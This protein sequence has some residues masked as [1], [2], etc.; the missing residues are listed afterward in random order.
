[1]ANYSSVV[2]ES[3]GTSIISSYKFTQYTTNRSSLPLLPIGAG[4]FDEQVVFQ[5][6]LFQPPQRN[7]CEES[8]GNFLK[9]YKQYTNKMKEATQKQMFYAKIFIVRKILIKAISVFDIMS[10]FWRSDFENNYFVAIHADN[11]LKKHYEHDKYVK[12]TIAVVRKFMSMSETFLLQNMNFAFQL[13]IEYFEYFIQKY[14]KESYDYGFK[15]SRNHWLSIEMANMV[16]TLCNDIK[17]KNE[18]R[19]NTRF[20]SKIFPEEICSLINEYSFIP[21]PISG[22][23]FV[24]FFADI[25]D[26]ANE[27]VKPEFEK[28]T[29]SISRRQVSTGA[30]TVDTFNVR[31]YDYKI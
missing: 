21:L 16:G 30:I 14:P 25:Y 1:M 6:F 8:N 23:T 31:I 10:V 20:F 26:Y 19:L 12:K 13:P 9:V 29:K 2:R 17:I 11:I 15:K 4:L 28:I 18:L 24:D 3:D 27:C 5:L 22:K 7:F